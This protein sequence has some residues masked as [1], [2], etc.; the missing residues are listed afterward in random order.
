MLFMLR[1]GGD[2]LSG[3]LQGN[4]AGP[5]AADD[6][7]IM[8]TQSGTQW[9]ALGH[10]F[11]DSRMWNGYDA[12]LVTSVGAEKND[13]TAFRDRIVGRAVLLDL[14]RFLGIEW[15]DVGRATPGAELDACAEAQG[16]AIER[17]DIVLVRF[18]HIAQCR[19]AG[20]WGAY[21]GGDAPGLAFDTLGWIADHEIAGVATD[22]WGAEVRP[23]E[24]TYATQPWHRVA[25]PAMGLLVGEIFD[26]DALAQDCATDGVYEMFFVACPLPITGAVG[27]PV[28]PI[29]VK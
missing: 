25:L 17:G 9:D 10:V 16:V 20:S 27:G 26:L 24:I 15:C 28:N 21:V 4:P 3:Q 19:A 23:N 8:P 6:V 22:T 11:F 1:D 2:T 29:A 7:V 13:I 12:S 18:G 14:P 5:G